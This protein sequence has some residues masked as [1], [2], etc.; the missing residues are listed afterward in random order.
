MHCSTPARALRARSFELMFWMRNMGD[1]H[2]ISYAYDFGATR[3]G[4]PRNYGV[5][6]RVSF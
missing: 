1:K 2:Y 3:L 4:D 6:L 5:T